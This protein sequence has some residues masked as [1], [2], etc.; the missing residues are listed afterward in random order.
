MKKVLKWLSVF[1]VA[2]TAIGLVATYFLNKKSD[3][4]EK[5]CACDTEDEDFDLDADLQPASREYVSLKK[6]SAEHTTDTNTIT[7]E[8]S[9]DNITDET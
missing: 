9:A 7:E 5:S 1:A 3:S 6:N 8:K 4:P 2:G